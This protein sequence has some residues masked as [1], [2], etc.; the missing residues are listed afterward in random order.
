MLR[1]V[2]VVGTGVSEEHTV[3]FI[4]VRKIEELGRT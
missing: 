1:R 4:R 2:A 3:S